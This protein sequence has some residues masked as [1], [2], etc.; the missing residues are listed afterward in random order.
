VG[1]ATVRSDDIQLP[2]ADSADAMRNVEFDRATS[3]YGTV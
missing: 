3:C 1:V 2:A